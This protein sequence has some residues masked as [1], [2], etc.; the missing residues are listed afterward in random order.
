MFL[1]L[2]PSDGIKIGKGKENGGITVLVKVMM[3]AVDNDSLPY[4]WLNTI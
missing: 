2:K 3:A 1:G 4:Q